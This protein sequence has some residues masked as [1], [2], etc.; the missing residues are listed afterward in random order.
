[1]SEFVF[2]YTFYSDLIKIVNKEAV[3][4]N[5]NEKE[6][7]KRETQLNKQLKKHNITFPMHVAAFEKHADFFTNYSL[8]DK[9][10]YFMFSNKNGEG[11]MVISN[12]M[13][14]FYASKD[15]VMDVITKKHLA[16]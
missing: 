10:I 1:M 11:W 3:K 8:H 13:E 4:A 5:L 15:D 16:A 9:T 7:K 6:M 2:M 12:G 14:N